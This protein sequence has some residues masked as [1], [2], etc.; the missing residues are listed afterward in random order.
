VRAV[1]PLPWPDGTHH[2]VTGGSDGSVQVWGA[3]SGRRITAWTG[4]RRGVTALTAMPGADGVYRIVV[5]D[6]DGAVTIWKPHT[7]KPEADL[8]AGGGWGQ[9][10]MAPTTSSP[11]AS[12]SGRRAGTLRVADVTGVTR[13][14][15]PR[16]GFASSDRV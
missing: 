14:D 8:R 4:S 13:C 12:S 9:P 6:I 7:G 1:A 11:A 2:V 10:R 15:D 16:V 5:G 3:G